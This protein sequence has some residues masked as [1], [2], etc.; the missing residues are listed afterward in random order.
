MK[1]KCFSVSNNDELTSFRDSLISSGENRG[2]WIGY[3]VSTNSWLDGRTT[4][5]GF[6]L[7]WWPTF[8]HIGNGA[9]ALC[10]PDT[11]NCQQIYFLTKSCQSTDSLVFCNNY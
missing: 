1:K 5:T 10:V 11:T 6:N 4:E 3:D 8:P 9:Y 2:V 7:P